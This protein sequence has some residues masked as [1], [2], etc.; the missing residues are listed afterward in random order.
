LLKDIVKNDKSYQV[1]LAGVWTLKDQK[2]L[3]D[4]AENN[5]SRNIRREAK[6]RL[7]ELKN[8]VSVK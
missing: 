7:E 8:K 2:I 1:R 4:F 3:S 5:K 6:E